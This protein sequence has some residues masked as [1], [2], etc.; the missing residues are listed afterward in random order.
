MLAV[1]EWVNDRDEPNSEVTE[2]DQ[3]ETLEDGTVGVDIEFEADTP[4]VS[5]TRTVLAAPEDDGD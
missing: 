5:V 3:P 2:P 1:P 4:G